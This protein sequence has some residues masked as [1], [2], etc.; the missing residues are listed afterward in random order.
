MRAS[1]KD[2]YHQ[3]ARRM[4]E[5][6]YFQDHPELVDLYRACY[7]TAKGVEDESHFMALM[8]AELETAFPHY[9]FAQYCVERS[10]STFH[11]CISCAEESGEV[12][13]KATAF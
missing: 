10:D 9:T 12:H 6:H 3:V 13:S 7:F 2:L 5:T 8:E 1:P 4:I 11:S